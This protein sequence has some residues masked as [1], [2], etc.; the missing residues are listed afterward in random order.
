[1]V[2][3][4]PSLT[5]FSC[6]H[7]YGQEDFRA[8]VGAL[9]EMALLPHTSRVLVD[10]FQRGQHSLQLACPKCVLGYLRSQVI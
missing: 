3:S 7:A 10:M 1:M 6:G 9:D 8:A 5:A 2:S 4:A